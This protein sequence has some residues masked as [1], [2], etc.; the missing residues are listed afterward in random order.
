MFPRSIRVSTIGAAVAAL[1][2]H[3]A[4]A[5]QA[6]DAPTQPTAAP[7]RVEITG[8]RIKR[9]DSEGVSPVT[10]I[11]AEEIKRSG[12]TTVTDVLRNLPQAAGGGLSNFDGSNSFSAGAST[13]SLRSLGSQSTLVLLNGRRIAPFA[14]A[15]PNAG[16][17]SVV[18]VD[19]LPLDVVERIEVLPSGAS[20]IYGSDAMAGV[21]NII[22]KR[23]FEGGFAEVTG[24][25]SGRGLFQTVSGSVTYGFGSLAENGYN[26][27][28]NLEVSRRRATSFKDAS[29]FLMDERLANSSRWPL[30]SRRGSTYAGNYYEA[31]FNP[32]TLGDAL[33]YSFVEPSPNCPASQLVNGT[34]RFDTLAYSDIMPS[35]ER[36]NLFVSAN[37]ELNADMQAFI[38]LGYNRNKTFYRGAPSVY[39]DNG[40]WYASGTGQ[41]V[42]VPEVLPVGHPSNPFDYEIGYRHRFTEVGDSNTDALMQATR[43]VAGVRGTAASWDY[44][45]ALTYSGNNYESTAFNKIRRSVLTDGVLNGTYNFLDPWSGAIT[46]D[47]LR[48]DST[49]TARSS[50]TMLDVRASR[51]IGRLS[52][53]A[54]GMALGAEV[55]HETRRATPDVAKTTGE[56]VGYGA[57]SADGSRN[58]LSAYTEFSLPVVK[59]LEVQLAAR[60]DRYS[61]YGSSFNPK[62]AA[63]W[64]ISPAFALRGGIETGFRA[65]SL[66]EIAKSS[67]SAFTSV[68]DPYRCFPEDPTDPTSEVVCETPGVGLLIEASPFL[69]PEKS[70]SFN[71]GFVVEPIDNLSISLD[72]FDIRR[73]NE[74]TTLDLDEILAN[75]FSGN[76]LY[77]GRVV[78]GPADPLHPDAPGPIQVIRT[79]Y[80]NAGETHAAGVDID[81]RYL[82]NLGES[83][84]LNLGAKMVYYTKYDYAYTDGAPMQSRLGYWNQPRWRGSLSVNWS[85]QTFD[86]GLTLNGVGGYKT[87]DPVDGETDADIC[88][89]NP[90][91]LGVCRTGGWSTLDL[92]VGMEV[93]KAW[94][95]D[96]TVRNLT[97]RKPPF[98]PNFFYTP[99][100]NSDFHNGQG[101]AF[102]A[103][104]SYRF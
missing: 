100:F 97:D 59:D 26:V 10:V 67:V 9:V 77:A 74:V 87:F 18:N 85:V 46:P 69:K 70:R 6:N 42:N 86:I 48:I 54:I 65:P 43:L 98:D 89:S 29:G 96:F 4:L 19:T 17:A 52:G 94:T 104:A 81:A 15:D 38:E 82:F 32:V 99:M 58:V 30:V 62:L 27:F 39:G 1:C 103:S 102:T 23:E 34:C 68:E 31:V 57:A 21:I 79:G 101:R 45:T 47:D 24:A 92:A 40:S 37:I 12:Q 33:Y 61:D 14:P 75:E 44:E 11:T 36:A 72:Y 41:L 93:T 76:P 71:L 78:R 2:A 63:N 20:A 60:A 28:A 13:V 5:Q 66:T 16:Q 88:A 22:T 91:R 90:S 64:K 7:Q 25:S 56:V 84:K 83:G 53:G 51:E 35:S 95:V 8:S 50:F 73:R 55:R 49:D 3:T 80:I